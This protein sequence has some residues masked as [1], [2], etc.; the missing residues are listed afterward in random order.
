MAIVVEFA[1]VAF[2]V[3]HLQFRGEIGGGIGQRPV[4]V[5]PLS[6]RARCR[7]RHEHGLLLEADDRFPDLRVRGHGKALQPIGARNS[8][9]RLVIMRPSA[10]DVG[11]GGKPLPRVIARGLARPLLV[12]MRHVDGILATKVGACRA[13]PRLSEN[14][15]GKRVVAEFPRGLHQRQDVLESPRV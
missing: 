3:V 8:H 14:H 10:H 12:I 15:V 11:T 2:V 6:L 13:L 4:D 7:S 1:H 5:L 9:A